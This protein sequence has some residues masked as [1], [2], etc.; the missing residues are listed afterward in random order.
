[1]RRPFVLTLSFIRKCIRLLSFQSNSRIW[2]ELHDSAFRRLGGTPRVLVL[3]NLSEAVLSPDFCDPTINPLYRDLLAH[4][5]SVTLPCRVRDP[6]RKG[7]V[8]C[9]ACSNSRQSA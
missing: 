8:E 1:M 9:S 5:N 4:Y 2:C 7:K 6:D 3:D